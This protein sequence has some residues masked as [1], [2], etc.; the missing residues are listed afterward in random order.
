MTRGPIRRVL[1]PIVRPVLRA[2][3]RALPVEDPWQKH[4]AKVAK[5]RFGQGNE[6]DWPWYFDGRSD[7]HVTSLKEVCRWLL[8]CKYAYDKA[9]FQE[10]DF[11]QHPVTFETTR[12]GDCEDHALWAWRKL[13]ELGIPAELVRGRCT[14]VTHPDS[15]A[16][17]WVIF[18]RNDR[19]YVLEATAKAPKRM[20][21]TLRKAKQ[22]YCPEVSVDAQFKTY[23]YDGNIETLKQRLEHG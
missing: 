10:D 23:L 15:G 6:H 2:L 13:T 20:V 7:V 12:K 3:A 18:R 4:E 8:N 19:P 22:Y 9:L 21:L 1:W 16:H 17:A 14:Y 11:W 5:H